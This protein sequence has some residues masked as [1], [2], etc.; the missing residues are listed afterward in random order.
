M[1]PVD[2]KRIAKNTLVLYIRM[3][4]LMIVNLY[5]SRVILDALGETDNGIYGTVGGIVTT[6]AF[7][8][9]TM[10]TACQRFFA[11]EM[12]RDDS[13]ALR[14]TFSMC[15]I[16]FMAIAVIV[17]ILCETAG[18][19]MVHD[20]IDVEDRMDAALVIFQTATVSLLFTIMRTP[21][22]GMVIIK[23]KMK[24]YTYIS[25]FE[26]LGN[27]GI[28]LLISHS[29][30][31]RL[32]LYAFLMM[33][34][35]IVVSVYYFLYCRTFWNECRFRFWWDRNKFREIFSFAGW[36]MI[37]SMA[38]SLKSQG[39]TVLI[40]MFFGNALV[41]AR[42][43]AGRVFST[44]QQFADNFTIA[45]KPQIMKSYAEG[46]REGMFKLVFQGSKFSY[47]LLFMVSLPVMLEVEP[48]IDV[49]LVKVPE[50][51]GLFTR[52][53]L[54]NALVEV[55]VSPL[56]TSMQ[57]YGNIRNYQIVCGGALL[58]I[59]PV[60][61]LMYK[62]GAPVE[63]IFYVSIV[64]CFIAIWLRVAIIHHYIGLRVRDYFVKVFLPVLTITAV[65]LP[66]PV[67]LE[68]FM[69]PSFV[70]FL[71]VCTTAVLSV[72]ASAY[73]LG[74]TGTERKHLNEQISGF[75]SDK[76]NIRPRC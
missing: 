62:L 53:I 33:G 24:V 55:F 34:V 27:L 54:I 20:K 38:N 73:F 6:F 35:N 30:S 9:N 25:V 18:L 5:A 19:W 3:A 64:I 46:D 22:Q 72:G 16:V 29:A 15:V 12:G 58:L 71:T 57:A 37:G 76:L 59:L 40:N 52:L 63:S 4:L 51:T 60:A 69:T 8:C 10:S 70:K 1:S 74:M 31:D 36:N 50:L 7:L 14:R 66:I 48:I 11:V 68:H 56:A 28:A 67:L 21:Y 47:Y 42:V 75:L 41:S 44:V 61:W 43:M 49:W 13:R 2:Q 26:G 39:I 17:A 32:I 23:E 65:S 45:V